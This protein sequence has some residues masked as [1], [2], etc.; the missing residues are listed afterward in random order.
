MK[1]LASFRKPPLHEVALMVQFEAVT[2][3]TSAHI[4]SFWQEVR[5]RLPHIQEQLPLPGVPIERA[6]SKQGKLQ[7]E[8]VQSPRI[9]T[10]FLD[11]EG[12]ELVQIQHDR[13][14]RN[15]R[16][17]GEDD[18]YPRYED[19]IRPRFAEDFTR[20]VNFVG[21]FGLGEVNPLQC[22][23]TYFNR[24]RSAEPIWGKPSDMHNAMT[25]HQPPMLDNLPAS[26]EQ[27]QLRQSFIIHDDDEFIGRL[28]T[29]LSPI[30][31]DGEAVIRYDLTAR[32]RPKSPT[33]EG[34]MEFLDLGRRLIVE[35]FERSTS[36]DMHEIW[37][38]E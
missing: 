18:V 6:G 2:E 4:G 35:C 21:S 25:T 32:G 15:W 1:P 7:L 16:K 38:K 29:E 36:A 27:S 12:R 31:I 30:E 37:G 28:Y 20:F 5:G 3:L 23:V 14:I 22:E 8:I 34:A 13:F 24:I 19:H 9:R 10:W 11:S 33:V 26:Y 17:T